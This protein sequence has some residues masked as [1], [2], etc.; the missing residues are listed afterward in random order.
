MNAHLL[1][2][3][4]T[5]RLAAPSSVVSNYG[6]TTTTTS[7]SSNLPGPAQAGAGS[8]TNRRDLLLGPAVL[9]TAY[10]A[11]CSPANASA[12]PESVDNAWER[13]GGGPADLVFPDEFEGE[14][15][16]DSVL[17]NIELP[18]GPE[19]VPDMKVNVRVWQ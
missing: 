3:L 9:A 8:T 4:N 16:V 19:F 10:A 2:L 6:E 11:A 7:N 14:W 1:S 17:T 15:V 12:L 5:P 18:L 13:V